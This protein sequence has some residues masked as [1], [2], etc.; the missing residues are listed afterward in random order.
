M[1]HL[2]LWA[3]IWLFEGRSNFYTTRSESNIIWTLVLT[4]DSLFVRNVLRKKSCIG[5]ANSVLCIETIKRKAYLKLSIVFAAGDSILPYGRIGVVLRVI[6]EEDE[7]RNRFSLV[8][9]PLPQTSRRLVALHVHLQRMFLI[10]YNNGTSHE[11]TNPEQT[12][13]T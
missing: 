13:T 9:R 2:P 4:F 12:D 11:Q 5:V 6:V 10:L 8:G 3:G 7:G 1:N